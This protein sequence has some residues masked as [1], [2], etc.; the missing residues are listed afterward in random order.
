MRGSQPAS[1]SGWREWLF[2]ERAGKECFVLFVPRDYK[3]WQ[4]PASPPLDIAWS[5]SWGWGRNE[6]AALGE[7]GRQTS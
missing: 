5:L 1:V 3:R 7:M 2:W 6:A 4:S